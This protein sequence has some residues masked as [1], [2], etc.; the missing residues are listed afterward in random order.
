M[1]SDIL[2][3]SRLVLD[4]EK[5]T[6]AYLRG[7]HVNYGTI[8]RRE[9]YKALSG[10]QLIGAGNVIWEGFHGG[11]Q[12]SRAVKIEGRFATEQMRWG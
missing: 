1:C 10:K 5:Y 7:S 9:A 6:Q 3:D 2:K 11:E 4:S 12:F 8:R